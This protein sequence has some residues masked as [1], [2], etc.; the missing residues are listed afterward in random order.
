MV[1]NQIF[2]NLLF[3]TFKCKVPFAV[4]MAAVDTYIPI[5][6]RGCIALHISHKFVL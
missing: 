1:V 6:K 3:V 4:N 2:E 5:K